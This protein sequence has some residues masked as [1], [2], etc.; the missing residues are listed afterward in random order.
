MRIVPNFL[1]ALLGIFEGIA[2]IEADAYRLLTKLGSTPVTEVCLLFVTPPVRLIHEWMDPFES[3]GLERCV[4]T[5]AYWQPH[6]GMLWKEST[7]VFGGVSL[8]KSQAVIYL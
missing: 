8:D 2:A 6:A 4:S 3:R 5:R 1:L 7:I